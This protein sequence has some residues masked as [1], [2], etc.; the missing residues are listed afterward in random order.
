[1]SCVAQFIHNKVKTKINNENYK[2][3]KSIRNVSE[4]MSFFQTLELSVTNFPKI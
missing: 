3:E 4:I 2:I 1:M